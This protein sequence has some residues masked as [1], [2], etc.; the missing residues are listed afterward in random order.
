MCEASA[1]PKVVQ[2]SA[3]EAY[4]VVYDDGKLRS[5]RSEESIM[6]TAIFIACRRSGVGRTVKEISALTNVSEKEISRSLKVMKR[7][8]IN[9]ASYSVSSSNAEDLLHRFCSHL[10]LPSHVAKAAE[11]IALRIREDGTLAGRSPTSIAA[12]T[13]WRSI[14]FNST[15]RSQ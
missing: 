13:I 11:H 2:D 10:V 5:K 6:A 1:L 8:L 7:L 15:F 12:A 14:S 9:N 3:K 4:K